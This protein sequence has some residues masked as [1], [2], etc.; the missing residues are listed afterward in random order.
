MSQQ[1]QAENLHQQGRQDWSEIERDVDALDAKLAASEISDEAYKAEFQALNDRA[2]EAD[3]Y[4]KRAADLNTLKGRAKALSDRA[5]QPAPV[6]PAVDPGGHYNAGSEPDPA[7]ISM[8]AGNLAG[9]ARVL[10][11]QYLR[12]AKLGGGRAALSDDGWRF[13]TTQGA[14]A[15][16]VAGIDRYLSAARGEALALTP[17]IDSSGGY[18]Q[19][20][21]VWNEVVSIRDRAANL[22]SR[23]RTITGIGG[24]LTIPT[25][26]VT[27]TFTAGSKK[28]GASVTA[29]DI[30][31]VFGRSA[32]TPHRHD[33]ILKIPEEF[34]EDP[35]FDAVGEI[36][37]AA[38]R[39][40]REALETDVLH[41]TGSGEPY[42]I[43]PAL[44]ALYAAG[45]TEVGIDLAGSGSAVVPADIQTFDLELHA[46]AR[47]NAVWIFNRPGLK[48][49]RLFRT[50]EGG[51]GT[52]EFMFKRSAAA[53][54]PDTL[55]GKEIIE[56]EFLT[57]TVTSPSSGDVLWLFG[58]LED[59]WLAVQKDLMLRILEELYAA[60]NMVGYKWTSARDG[61]LVRGDA[62]IYQRV[63]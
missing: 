16:E 7:E 39:S 34:F 62:F 45:G 59:Y 52:G 9:R 28:T 31:E 56:T 23:I 24:R 10:L 33:A 42:G 57:D 25:S 18:V 5:R 26:K 61:S 21:Q 12:P 20:E 46:A 44:K 29:L 4:F 14:Q 15:E 6:R 19:A 2:D 54:Q 36:A 49:V 47:V 38:E 13:L 8:P 51:S 1:A 37:R 30:T 11:N 50:E 58:D 40:D 17:Y 27:I 48:K 41:G 53:G 63:Q 60:E 35:A 32:L 43:V 3:A 55:N 22:P